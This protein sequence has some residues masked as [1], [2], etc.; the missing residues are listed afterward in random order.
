MAAVW[1]PCD[2]VE[3]AVVNA[4]ASLHVCLADKVSSIDSALNI[5]SINTSTNAADLL[6][7]STEFSAF[8]ESIPVLPFGPLQADLVCASDLIQKMLSAIQ[9]T[10]D[11]FHDE[12]QELHIEALF[13]E[14]DCGHPMN[15][16]MDLQGCLGILEAPSPTYFP[17][18][19]VGNA[20]VNQILEMES[21]AP[22]T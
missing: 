8:L 11:L 15:A 1:Q 21:S 20:L 12:V 3:A 9:I 19:I 6:S 22:V 2:L 13:D 5:D 16:S 4:F 10:T 18:Y 7:D 17:Y 14:A